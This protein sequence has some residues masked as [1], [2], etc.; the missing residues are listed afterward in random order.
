[1]WKVKKSLLEDL[2]KSAQM[3]YPDEF[4]C[5]LGGDSKK[6]EITEIIFLPTQTDEMSA[7][8][9]ESTMPY[10]PT[11]LGSVHSHPDSIGAPSG[12]D[13]KFFSKYAIN[14]IIG[15]PFIVENIAFFDSKSKPAR[16][17]IE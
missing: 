15:Y 5:F 13:K 17:T 6:M 8:I 3:Y 12:A 10:D 1:M 4:L 14:A 16:V 7:S 9:M 2:C 11:I